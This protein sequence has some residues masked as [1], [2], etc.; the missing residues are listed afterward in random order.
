MQAPAEQ[1]I[2]R[3][4][5]MGAGELEVEVVSEGFQVD[6]GGVHLGVKITPQLVV[7]AAGSYGDSLQA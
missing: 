3:W 5:Q 6:I 7:P 2:E 4:L 1:G